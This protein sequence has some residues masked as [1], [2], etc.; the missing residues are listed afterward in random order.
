M[1][2]PFHDPTFAQ[3][4]KGQAEQMRNLR[5]IFRKNSL[6]NRDSLRKLQTL[7][8]GQVLD[9]HQTNKE[10]AKLQEANDNFE[11]IMA[12][13]RRIEARVHEQPGVNTRRWCSNSTCEVNKSPVDMER[14]AWRKPFYKQVPHLDPPPDSRFEP[15]DCFP[16]IASKYSSVLKNAVP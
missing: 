2:S 7:E 16:G 4:A 8:V 6:R 13:K 9:R 1:K 5:S 15:F 3:A 12:E 10:L 14:Q 11:A